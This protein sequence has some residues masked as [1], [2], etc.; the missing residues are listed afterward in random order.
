MSEQVA[1]T[2][3]AHAHKHL[4]EVRTR[5][6]E[7]GDVS[8]TSYC[9]GQ[10]GLASARR[11]YEECSLGNLTTEVG[12]LLWVLEE[13]D[14]LLYLLLGFAESGHVLEGN[15]HLVVFFIDLSL[16]AAHIEDAADTA[17]TTSV[18]AAHASEEDEPEEENHDERGKDVE[19]DVP[20]TARLLVANIGLEL[21]VFGLA[22]PFDIFGKLVGRGYV[23]LDGELTV[24]GLGLVISLLDALKIFG[25]G[26]LL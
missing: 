20:S 7:E 14:N 25:F 15:A 26:C 2:A 18:L 5:H 8:F 6:G 1:H 12:E 19:Q 23:G 21:A 11:A 24:F 3:G 22:P 10:E 4:N 16:A 9:L 17:A 13:L